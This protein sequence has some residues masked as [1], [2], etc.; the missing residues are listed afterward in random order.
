MLH[1]VVSKKLTEVSEVLAVPIIRVMME[2]V[3]TS[4]NVSQFLR[5]H[6]AASQKTVIFIFPA[7]GT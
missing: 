4:K 5:L 3:S 6:G 2:A 1:R 7:A